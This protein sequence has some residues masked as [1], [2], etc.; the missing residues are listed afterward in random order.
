LP[1]GELVNDASQGVQ[2]ATI[3]ALSVRWA[4]SYDWRA[5]ETSLN[6]LPQFKSEIDGVG[7]HFIHVRSAHENA[8]PVIITHGWPGSIVEMLAVIG[9]LTDPTAYG[10]TAGDAFDVVVPSRPGFGFSDAPI[11]LGWGPNRVAQAWAELMST[12]GYRA[13]LDFRT[14]PARR[15]VQECAGRLVICLRSA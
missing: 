8:L 3:Q 7:I 5:F 1:P 12:L 2:L 15:A 13:A 10:G 14:C 11:S 9:P 4:R 6:A